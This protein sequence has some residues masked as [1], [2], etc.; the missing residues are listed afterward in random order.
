MPELDLSNLNSEVVV[1]KA[2]RYGKNGMS[3]LPP[4]RS[5]PMLLSQIPQQFRT[6][7]YIGPR[8]SSV[9]SAIEAYSPLKALQE[10]G[11]IPKDEP[12]KIVEPPPIPPR[13]EVPAEQIESS[14]ISPE[15]ATKT[16]K[17]TKSIPPKEG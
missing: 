13:A 3:T 14:P 4:D 12:P 1:I 6:L 11:A 5:R 16:V 9:P 7:E 17:T 15:T 8:P 10:T 2:I